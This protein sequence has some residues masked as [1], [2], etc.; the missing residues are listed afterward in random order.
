MGSVVEEGLRGGRS[1]GIAI[2]VI[3]RG[4]EDAWLLS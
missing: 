4:L 1:K 3:E 2:A